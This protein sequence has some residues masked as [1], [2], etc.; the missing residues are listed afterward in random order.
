MSLGRSLTRGLEFLLGTK[1]GFEKLEPSLG[2]E[3][4]PRTLF[5]TTHR[6]SHPVF[7]F[8]EG[9]LRNK[10]VSRSLACPTGGVLERLPQLRAKRLRPPAAPTL[11]RRLTTEGPNQR[12]AMHLEHPAPFVQNPPLLGAATSAVAHALR[13]KVLLPRSP[14]HHRLH[15]GRLFLPPPSVAPILRQPVLP[16]ASPFLLIRKS[17]PVPGSFIYEATRPIP[18]MVSDL[19]SG[20]TG[21]I[22]AR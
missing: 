19:S 14:T 22:R 13:S 5:S 4:R 11:A 8:R 17:Y 9:A 12:L 3:L 18:R 2:Q 1:S 10:G 15:L 7:S 6:H 21:T 16:L 20:R